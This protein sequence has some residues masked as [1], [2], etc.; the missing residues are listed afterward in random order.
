MHLR[1]V[2]NVFSLFVAPAPPIIKTR[3]C[4]SC[5]N[6][7]LIRWESGNIN[8]VESYTVEIFKVTTETQDNLVTE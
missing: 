4:L 8:P 3:E 2:N 6:A 7:A 5:E 1:S